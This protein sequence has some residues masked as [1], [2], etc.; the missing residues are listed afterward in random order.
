MLAALERGDC[1]PSRGGVDR[2]SY[3]NETDASNV[4]RSSRGGVDRNIIKAENTGA[5]NSRPSR[6]G[7][8]RNV[9]ADVVADGGIGRPRVGAWIETR[10]VPVLAGLEQAQD[11]VVFGAGA[12]ARWDVGDVDAL[13][14]GGLLKPAGRAQSVVCLGCEHRCISDVNVSTLRSGQLRAFVVCACRRKWGGSRLLLAACAS[15]RPPHECLP[16]FS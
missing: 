2:N 9:T 3:P 16:G 12:V 4:R 5:V 1:R 6:G 15:G 13:I 11:A 14:G 7:V 10:L 8:D